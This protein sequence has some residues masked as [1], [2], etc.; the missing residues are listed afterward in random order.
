MNDYAF[1]INLMMLLVILFLPIMGIMMAITPY[2]MKKSEV[3]TVTVPASANK[4]PFIKKL[5]AAYAAIEC[6]VTLVVTMIALVFLLTNNPFG[7]IFG[8]GIGAL[9]IFLFGYGVMLRYRK[10]VQAYKKQQGWEAEHQEVVAVFGEKETP[11]PISLKWNLLYIPISLITLGVGIAGYDIMPDQVPMNMGIDGQIT[12]IDKSFIVILFPLFV[13]IFMAVCFIFCHWSITR[14][15]KLSDPSAPVSS[16]FAYGIFARAQSLMLLVCGLAINFA[17]ILMPLSFMEVVSL[18]QCAILIIVICMIV[19]A[20]WFG[21]SVAYGQGGARVFKQL[22]GP[23]TLLADDDQFWK[24][25]IL[26]CNREDPN[27][28]LPARFGIGWT[29]NLA[30]PAV[31]VIGVVA[32]LITIVFVVGIMMLI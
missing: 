13:Q 17:L 29:V 18:V 1:D 16:T 12:T 4:D 10:K 19:M 28:F 8:V 26:Y 23:T 7:V 25:G 30:R 6:L 3:F 22:D 32:I 11:R 21:I 14:S 27:W 9:V 5:K 2:L 20:G 24:L 15:K 31:W